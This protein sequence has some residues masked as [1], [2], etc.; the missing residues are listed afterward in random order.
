M[1]D[2]ER[3]QKL[4]DRIYD[5]ADTNNMK[6]NQDKFQLLR[7]G[8]NI[9]IKEDTYYFS[10]EMKSVIEEKRLYKRSRCID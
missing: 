8:K 9:N 2:V 5:W 6:W 3:T 7:I 1:G 10:P 4:L